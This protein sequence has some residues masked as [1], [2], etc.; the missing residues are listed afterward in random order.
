MEHL[1][2][3]T[4]DEKEVAS[5]VEEEYSPVRII[6]EDE[7]SPSVHPIYPHLS[8]QQQLIKVSLNL[9]KEVSHNFKKEA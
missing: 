7:T 2:K 5:G 4:K 6:P 3:E 1:G 8:E 9:P